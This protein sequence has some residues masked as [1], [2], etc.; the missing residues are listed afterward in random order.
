M[1]ESADF[2]ILFVCLGNICRSPMA[3]GAF[4]TL[5]KQKNLSNKYY[6][7]SAGTSAY[8]LGDQP[9]KRMCETALKHGITLSHAAQQLT[10]EDF[11]AFNVIVAMDKSNYEDILKIKPQGVNTKV[12][13]MRD[14]DKLGSGQDV[15]DPYYGG[16]QGFE[17][18]YDIVMRSC[19]ELLNELEKA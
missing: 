1:S 11:G 5:L 13:L 15:P 8:H 3:E 7:D 16:V 19:E 17:E 12:V 6:C 2:K 18:V 9:D 4:K 14:Y 10:V